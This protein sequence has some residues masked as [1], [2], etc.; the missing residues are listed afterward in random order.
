ML[1]GIFSNLCAFMASIA[2]LGIYGEK[3]DAVFFLVFAV[4]FRIIEYH[5]PRKS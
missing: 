3:I 5:E 4:L 1:W 2:Y